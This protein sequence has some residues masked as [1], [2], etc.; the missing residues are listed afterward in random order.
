MI[1]VPPTLT[2]ARD[3]RTA[4]AAILL[5]LLAPLA[6]AEERNSSL[7]L[8]SSE[9]SSD[10]VGSKVACTASDPSP[11]A[12][13]MGHAPH[14]PS[15]TAATRHGAGSYARE[16]SPENNS[17]EAG[18]ESGP[19]GTLFRLLGTTAY[20]VSAGD[21]VS[22]HYALRN[23]YEEL[24]PLQRNEGA[25]LAAHV[26]LP[27]LVNWGTAELHKDGHE[28]VALWIRIGMVAAYGYATAHNLRNAV[29]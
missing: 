28:K 16:K 11:V 17:T 26:A 12:A 5:F 3:L 15:A 22:T 7:A 9:C 14:Q 20:F 4:R 8:H 2:A 27:V 10:G 13:W 25:R 29:R 18:I 1:S 19:Q 24:N 6:S 23:G 21:Y